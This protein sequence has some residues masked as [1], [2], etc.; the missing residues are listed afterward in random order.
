MVHR[1]T[2]TAMPPKAHA[3]NLV[4]FALAAL[5]CSLGIRSDTLPHPPAARCH[6]ARMIDVVFSAR[7]TH[8]SIH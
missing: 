7:G 5:F 8:A 2:V 3:W 4:P 1:V 6:F